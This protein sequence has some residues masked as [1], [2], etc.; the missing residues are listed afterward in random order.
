MPLH[1]L[2]FNLMDRTP[3]LAARQG[4]ALVQRIVSTFRRFLSTGGS[5]S[6]R[7]TILVGHDTNI[8]NIGGMLGL[9]WSLPSYL[10]DQTPPAGALHFELL[11]ERRTGLHSVR[12]SYVAQTPNQMRQATPLDRAR[13]PERTVA[14]IDD[15]RT[16]RGGVCP[17]PRF[18]RLA[19]RSIDRACVP[20][21]R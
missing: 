3:Y 17:W 12:V 6:P 11:R 13:P 8:F 1:L 18:A 7:L 5:S 10:P 20:A 16:G 2:R 4:S 15:C 9:H 19:E 14:R 21:E